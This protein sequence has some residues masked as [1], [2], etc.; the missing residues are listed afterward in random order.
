ML[1]NFLFLVH[2]F[3]MSLQDTVSEFQPIT[4]KNMNAVK[5]L[6]R[7]DTKY[8]LSLEVLP[9]I[10]REI[11]SDYRSLD[12]NK[13]R[14]FSYDSLYFDTPENSMY[15][16]HHNGKLDRYKIRFRKYVSS[17][18]CFLEI[19][20][21]LKG[22]RTVKDRITVGCIETVL[23]DTS[24]DFIASNSPFKDGNLVP[25]I[26]T[27]FSRITLV[28]KQLTERVTI[29][30]ALQFHKNGVTRTVGNIA[31]IE[32]KRD[33]TAGHSNLIQALEKYGVHPKGFSKY[34]IGR[35]LTEP[36][37]KSNRFKE[38]IL[39]INKISNG[40]YSYRNHTHN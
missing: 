36:E 33:G 28:N 23:S 31:I 35:A 29:D 9:L 40:N 11:Q 2:F 15:L 13:E 18:L 3:Y 19:K 7:I 21:K 4:L 32:L 24:K 34:C 12:I 14:V 25:M 37:L 38:R 8:V 17:N 6:N 39:T 5:L 22:S 20:H 1:D 27:D 10:F 26:H 30:V 16:A